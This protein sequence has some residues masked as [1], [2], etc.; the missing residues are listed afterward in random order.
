[1]TLRLDYEVLYLRVV[2]GVGLKVS[3]L[4][5]LVNKALVRDM[6]EIGV[7]YPNKLMGTSSKDLEYQPYEEMDRGNVMVTLGDFMKLRPPFFTG[8]NPKEYL[9]VS[10]IVG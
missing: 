7:E 8:T 6:L 10:L 9:K 4:G 1:M 2:G 5:L 3:L